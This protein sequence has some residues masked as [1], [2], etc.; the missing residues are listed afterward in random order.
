M[1]YLGQK[2]MNINFGEIIR[3]FGIMLSI[4]IETR[5]MVLYPSYFVE[6]SIIHLYREYYVQLRGCDYWG[7]YFI[8]VIIFKQICSSFQPESGT[9]F[10]EEKHYQ[11]RYFV[12]MFNDKAKTI[13][14][15]IAWCIWWGINWH[16]DQELFCMDA[17]QR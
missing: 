9:Y 16:E 12:R 10:C 2:C 1:L 17:Q 5:N 7:G 3:F 14:S 13:F 8:T 6:D 4:S 11:L 15:W